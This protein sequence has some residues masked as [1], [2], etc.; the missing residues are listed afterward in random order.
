MN[1]TAIK[2]RLFALTDPADPPAGILAHLRDCAGCREAQV[3]LIQ[4]EGQIPHVPVPA[5]SAKAALAAKFRGE[6]TLWDRAQF[7]LRTVERW[8]VVTVGMAA[9]LLL[10]FLAWSLAPH[11]QPIVKTRQPSSA[12]DVLLVRLVEHNLSLALVEAPRQQVETL[13]Q[14]A[15]DLRGQ[16]D[17]LLRYGDGLEGKES[18]KDLADWYGQVVRMSVARARRVPPRERRDVLDPIVKQLGA[19]HDD[20]QQRAQQLHNVSADHPLCI[21]AFAAGNAREQLDVLL[22][23]DMSGV[24]VPGRGV[25]LARLPTETVLLRRAA[26]VPVLFAAA[27]NTARAETPVRTPVQAAEQARKFQH[28]RKLIQTLVDSCLRM[29]EQQQPDPVQRAASCTVVAE[30]LAEAVERSA[31]EQDAVRTQEA[32]LLLK[33]LL[34]RGVAFNLTTAGGTI[35]LGDVREPEMVQIGDH[36]SRIAQQLEENLLRLPDAETRAKLPKT[37]QAIQDGRAEVFKSLKG[38]G[39]Y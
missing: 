28:N 17:P 30:R 12:P 29:A 5:S 11:E 27:Q 18:L 33:K 25:G 4:M 21:I 22:K 3:R 7:H 19:A 1:C 2:R 37:L 8:H 20:A 14:L 39:A 34:Q 38:R 32:A 16:S 31:A 35:P 23:H 26:L 6:T 24:P 36:V 10:F 15:E 9:S 13:S